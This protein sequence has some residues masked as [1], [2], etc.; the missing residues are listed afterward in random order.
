MFV[1]N[2]LGEVYVTKIEEMILEDKERHIRQSQDKIEAKVQVDS[3]VHIK[4]LKSVKQIS[5]G[6]DHFL[7]LDTKG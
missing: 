1:L 7:C 4:D 3:L 6:N 5:C 2:N